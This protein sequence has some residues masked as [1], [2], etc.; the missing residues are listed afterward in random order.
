MILLED[1]LFKIDQIPDNKWNPT[2]LPLD[3]TEQAAVLFALED[4]SIQN[5]SKAEY[6]AAIVSALGK[7][8]QYRDGQ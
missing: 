5:N 6:R 8:K 1:I 4:Y 2:R 3:G 7:V